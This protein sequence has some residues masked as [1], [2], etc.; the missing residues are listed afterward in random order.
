MKIDARHWQELYAGKV[1]VETSWFRPQ[2][3]ESLR[4]I[5]GRKLP[6][7]AALID[8]GAGRSSL[9][10]DL[11]LRGFR[12]LTA[13]DISPAALTQARRR[14]GLSGDLVRWITG[15][16]LSA[17]LPA[18]RYD[19]W[20]D[21][22]AF[23]FL[24]EP[25]QQERYAAVAARSVRPGRFLLVATFAPDGPERCSNLPVC[26]YDAASL[27]ER[28]AADFVRVTEAREEHRTPAGTIQPFTYLLLRRTD[29]E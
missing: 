21:R 14:M 12:D 1:E 16:V 25:A 22:A 9:V 7:D 8:V 20:H 17:E 23:H 15:D 3:D 19:L 6:A 26:R 13:L 18:A 5:D 24:T 28:F 4:L 10:D 2:L 11:I 27:A 29:T